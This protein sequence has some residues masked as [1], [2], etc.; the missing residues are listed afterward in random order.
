MKFLHST[1]ITTILSLFAS[2]C[3]TQFVNDGSPMFHCKGVTFYSE[4]VR[5]SAE[6]AH[7]AY[8]GSINGYPMEISSEIITGPPPHKLFPMVRDVDVYSGG[9]VSYY[10]LFIDGNGQQRGVGYSIE[11]GYQLCD[12]Y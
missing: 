5:K 1:E 11:V 6:T 8:F 7:N 9:A 2:L 10:F 12:A 4:S 3:A